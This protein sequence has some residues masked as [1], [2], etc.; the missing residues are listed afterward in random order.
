MRVWV[1]D[2]FAQSYSQMLYDLFYNYDYETAPRNQKI[3]EFIN[4]CLIITNPYS[5]LFKNE[6]RSVPLKYLA[7]ELLLYFSGSNLAEH[8]VQASKFWKNIAN[9]DGTINSAYGYLLFCLDDAKEKNCS[10]WEW[11]VRSLIKDKDSRQAILHYNRPRHQY[12]NNKDFVC[13]MS[14]QFFIRDNKLHMNTFIRSQDVFFGSTFDIPFFTLL[15]QC[16]LN[17][18]SKVYPDLEMGYYYHNMG[19]CHLYE[20]N[21]EVVENMLR[22][23]FTED[24]LPHLKERPILNSNLQDILNNKYTGDDEFLKW[25]QNNKN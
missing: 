24:E 12:F 23:V 9:E 11:A 8:F 2:S 5:N 15:M 6:I 4:C 10:Q 1:G 21:F 19:S 22:H 16:M 25:I 14:N 3:R 18:L 17:E 20:R 13:T 7:N